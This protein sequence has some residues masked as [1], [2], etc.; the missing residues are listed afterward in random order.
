MIR[1]A[2]CSPFFVLIQVDRQQDRVCAFGHFDLYSTSVNWVL[3]QTDQ[4]VVAFEHTF[5][6]TAKRH[7]ETGESQN[8]RA[9]IVCE[10]KSVTPR[11]PR[12]ELG[13]IHQNSNHQVRPHRTDCVSNRI[14]TR[15]ILAYQHAAREP[16]THSNE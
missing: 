12:W 16:R 13:T 9:G 11:P 3:P 10:A 1:P 5:R 15:K 4:A 2:I 6:L 14:R 7:T 8:R